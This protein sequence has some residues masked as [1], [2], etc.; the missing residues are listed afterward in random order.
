LDS[1]REPLGES[2]PLDGLIDRRKQ[3]GR[4]SAG[5]VLHKDAPG[6]TVD[7]PFKGLIMITHRHRTIPRAGLRLILHVPAMPRVHY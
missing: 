5:S 7:F 2:D 4:C 6:D 1:D 3:A